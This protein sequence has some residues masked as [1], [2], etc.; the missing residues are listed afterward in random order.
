MGQSASTSFTITTP[1]PSL[2][3]SAVEPYDYTTNLPDECLSLI[4]QSLNNSDRKHCSLVC[5]RWLKI[6]GQCRH[7]LS[8]KAQSDLISMIPSLFTRFDS[9]TKLTLKND[10]RSL[11][12]SDDGVVMISLRCRNLTRLKLRAC[13]EIS[14]V[15][16]MVLSENCK[17]LK[18][19]NF[20]SCSFGVKGMNAVLNN[21]LVLE[22]LT[23]KRLRGIKDGSAEVIGP[24]L[25][26]GSLKMIC[27]KELHNGQCFAPLI[28]GA[29]GLK[30]LKIFRC[31]GDWDLVF[32]AVGDKVNG[33]VEIHLERIQMS[34]SGL[35]ALS[36]CSGVEILHL[37]KTPD[38]TNIGLALFAERC[39]LLRK[40]HIDGWK[41]NRIADDGLI[42]VA[43]SCWNLQELVLIGVNPTKLSFEALA[44]NCLN[45]ERLALCGSDTVGDT[46]LCCIAEKCMALKKLCIKNCPITDNG[47]EALVTGCPNLVKV[48]G[49]KCRGVTS[50]GADRLRTTRALLV[51]NLDTPETPIASEGGAQ[52]NA[53][54]LPPSTLQIP[55]LRNASGSTSRSTSVKSRLG[56]SSRRNFVAYTLRR[57]GS[58]SSS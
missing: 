38:C 16:M 19:V 44:S 39:K 18:K 46:E 22:E 58:R 47:M 52:E 4:F 57:L 32:E 9:V 42:V 17:R 24:G 5:H 41:T 8:L 15:G 34:D 36:K 33:I 7:R 35:T 37:V 10:R 45:L 28:S 55:T 43:K 3:D 56:F 1:S 27:L 2:P 26:A 40:L 23:V 30:S 29:K 6:E 31:S 54:E 21:C 11:S 20:G 53:I 13:R 50:E 49:K 48:K 12:I 25:A 51:V 14:D